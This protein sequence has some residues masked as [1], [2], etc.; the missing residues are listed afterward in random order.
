MNKLILP[1]HTIIQIK[2]PVLVSN[3][4]ELKEIEKFQHRHPSMNME[5]AAMKW[6]NKNAAA[7]RQNYHPIQGV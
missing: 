6:I 5:Q 1:D 7:W 2:E 3:L 4:L